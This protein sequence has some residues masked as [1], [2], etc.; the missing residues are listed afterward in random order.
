M[1]EPDREFQQRLLTTFRGEAEEHVRAISG[2]LIDLEN[3]PRV[4][5]RA[6]IVEKIFRE[7]HSLKGAARAV[8][9]KE[10]ETICQS[11]EGILAQAKRREIAITADALDVLHRAMDEI[12]RLLMATRGERPEKGPSNAA[13]LLSRLEAISRG[14]AAVEL[15]GQPD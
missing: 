3:T 14:S 7:A 4:E 10:I 8:N 15:S 1:P 2:G 13:N 11:M 9:L 12:E 6:Q 5:E